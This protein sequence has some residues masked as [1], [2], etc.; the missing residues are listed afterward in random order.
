M[1]RGR[2]GQTVY[3]AD[4]VGDLSIYVVES[5]T[6]QRHRQNGTHASDHTLGA[7]F[8]S[9]SAINGTPRRDK[10]VCNGACRLWRCSRDTF[11]DLGLDSLPP[12][13]IDSVTAHR[14][15]LRA[16][17]QHFVFAHMPRLNDVVNSFF[18]V[19]VGTRLLWFLLW[20]LLWRIK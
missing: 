18:K 1:Y 8:G 6:V 10:M 11:H 7:I 17:E 12:T 13:V 20:F 3:D 4:D 19:R 15:V 5:G 14:L 2:T 16:T 9:N